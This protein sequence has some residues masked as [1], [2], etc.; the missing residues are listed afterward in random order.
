MATPV[1]YSPC[2]F[3]AAV[4]CVAALPV[5]AMAE[6][7]TPDGGSA[8]QLISQVQE[9]ESRRESDVR[10]IV[11]TRRY[12]LK[13]KRWEQDATMTVRVSYESGVGKRFEII[14]MENADGLQKRVFHKLLEGEMEG[15]RKDAPNAE[16]SITL[17]NY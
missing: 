7:R 14:S 16:S 12:V 17:A 6:L 9:A 13:N 5:C 15:S 3:V 8:I 4:A 2:S 10:K 11:S 1:S